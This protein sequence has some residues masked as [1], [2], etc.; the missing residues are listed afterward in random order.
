M[1]RYNEECAASDK[2]AEKLIE[3]GYENV[4]DL[5]VDIKGYKQAGFL[6]TQYEDSVWQSTHSRINTV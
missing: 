1:F 2:A 6:I 5:A 4:A 3:L